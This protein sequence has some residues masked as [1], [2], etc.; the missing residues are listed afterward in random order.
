MQFLDLCACWDDQKRYLSHSDELYYMTI[1][2][3]AA[4]IMVVHVW[5]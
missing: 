2:L 1:G 5:C 4:N 3:F